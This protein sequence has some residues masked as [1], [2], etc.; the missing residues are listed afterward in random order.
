MQ[1]FDDRWMELY[2]YNLANDLIFV[3]IEY[4]VDQVKRSTLDNSY[5]DDEVNSKGVGFETDIQKVLIIFRENFDI[6]SYPL[7]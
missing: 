7:Y 5:T 4:L 6:N 3:V 1:L 2:Q